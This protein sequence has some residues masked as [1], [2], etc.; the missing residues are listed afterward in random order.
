MFSTSV[1]VDCLSHPS[2][3][4]AGNIQ[5]NINQPHVNEVGRMFACTNKK[6]RDKMLVLR[7]D[8]SDNVTRHQ[9]IACVLLKL[10]RVTV[11]DY[12]NTNEVSKVF[13]RMKFIVDYQDEPCFVLDC[14][15]FD[16]RYSI[17]CYQY[18]MGA[19][20][21]WDT[22]H[23]YHKT[24]SKFYKG[25]LNSAEMVQWLVDYLSPHVR[26]LMTPIAAESVTH[27]DS[28]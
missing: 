28:D 5:L 19:C 27:S 16:D 23:G 25:D 15:S 1:F 13:E 20:S 4:K 11:S 7:K 24:G 17:T 12:S 3:T 6:Y 18:T 8:L 2:T 9:H 14:G 26:A 21:K 22:K 10:I